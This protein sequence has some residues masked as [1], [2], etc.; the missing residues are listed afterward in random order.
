MCDVDRSSALVALGI[1][2]SR[3]TGFLRQR[4]F[5]HYFG[6]QSDAADAFMA[7]FRIP[8]FLQNLFGEGALSAS[9][10]PVYAALVARDDRREAARVAGA[11]AALISLLTTALVLIG[12]LLTPALVWLIAPG[13]E[14]A[15]RDLTVAIVRV[16][17]PGAGLLVL[18]AWCLGVLNSHRRF[19]LSYLAPVIWNV[20]MIATLLWWGA[21]V[22]LPQLAI[23]L[24][25]GAVVGSA[26]QLLVQLPAVLALVPDLRLRLEWSGDVRATVR[27]FVPVFFSRGVVQVSA[28]IDQVLA[29]LLPTGAVTGLANAQL[30]YTLPVSLFGLSV[31]A[32]SLPAMSAAVG[33]TRPAL[34]A[35]ASTEA[36]ARSPSSSSH[37][38]WR[39]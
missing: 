10:I 21:H 22:D 30:L 15:K 13:F 25:W 31:S 34:F 17:F 29:S 35:I 33:L 39:S 18:S 2:C 12:V 4:V 6:L 24:A 36:S 27:N 8:N 37:Q 32:A 11:V 16:L 1:F 23:I 7:A 28:Y 19:L 9:F 20:A 38:P 3:L 26:L 5:A 14:G